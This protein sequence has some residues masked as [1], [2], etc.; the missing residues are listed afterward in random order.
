MQNLVNL[1]KSKKIIM[2][3]VKF[4]AIYNQLS[5]EIGEKICDFALVLGYVIFVASHTSPPKCGV[6]T[7]SP[8]GASEQAIPGI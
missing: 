4:E 6:S 2:I 7:P 5:P 3:C 8:P 1:A